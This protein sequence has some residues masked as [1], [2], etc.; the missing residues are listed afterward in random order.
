MSLVTLPTTFTPSSSCLVSSNVWEIITS[1]PFCPTPCHYFLQGPP[2]TSDCLPLSYQESPS[3][4]YLPGGQ[5]CPPGYESACV[6]TK[7]LGAYT[8]SLEICCPRFVY[9]RP[10]V[11]RN[12]LCLPSCQYLQQ[13][14]MPVQSDPLVANDSGLL[15]SV[16]SGWNS[17]NNYDGDCISNRHYLNYHC[18][19]NCWSCER[20][21][22]CH[23]NTWPDHG[24]PPQ[25]APWQ[26]IDTAQSPNATAGATS[27]SISQSSGPNTT[28]IALI[29]VVV[30]LV[31]AIILGFVIRKFYWGKNRRRTSAHVRLGAKPSPNSASNR[32]ELRRFMSSVA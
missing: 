11:S 9:P 3:T 6:S 27:N 25:D 5:G 8:V 18:H 26:T 13:L 10:L 23:Q 22:N 24:K 15:Q 14:P 12:Y 20:L 4:F 16:P 21:R 28:I 30:F 29:C 1:T 32:A 19:G 31:I 2:S 17:N 7:S